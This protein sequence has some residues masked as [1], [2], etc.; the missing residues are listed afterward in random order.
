MYDA[1]AR[2]PP[3]EGIVGG[4]HAQPLEL[5]NVSAPFAAHIVSD[6]VDV[7]TPGC[8]DRPAVSRIVD[9]HAELPVELPWFGYGVVA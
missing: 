9:H 5:S 8:H 7:R 1:A 2:E 3:W 6:G 4:Q